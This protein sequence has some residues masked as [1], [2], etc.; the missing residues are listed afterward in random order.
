VVAEVRHGIHPGDVFKWRVDTG[1]CDSQGYP[2]L[3][4]VMGRR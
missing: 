1:V 2:F 4:I 3:Y